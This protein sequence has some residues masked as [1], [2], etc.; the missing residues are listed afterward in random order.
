MSI[1][2]SYRLSA[3]LLL[4]VTSIMPAQAQAQGAEWL[5]RCSRSIG[6]SNAPEQVSYG[7][8]TLGKAENAQGRASLTYTATSHGSAT[9][10]LTAAK[11]M[12]SQ[13]SGATLSVGYLGLVDSA[14]PHASKSKVGSVSIMASGR[15]G[16]PLAG[17]VTLKLVIDGKAFGPYEP[18]ASSVESGLY[19]VWLDTA[20]TDGDSQPPVLSA[21]KFAE[22]AKAVDAMKA[23]RL[24]VLQDRAEVA[25]MDLPLTSFKTMRDG[26]PEWAAGTRARVKGNTWC[27]A[28]DQDVN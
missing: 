15:N 6:G 12:L 24:I 5:T 21:K 13:Y 16:K 23:A 18:K 7:F 2:F 19:S 8:S 25:Y 22:L 9:V 27:L 28:G 14:A 1:R 11:D 20:Q 10:Y 17:H 4:A 3:S 26:L